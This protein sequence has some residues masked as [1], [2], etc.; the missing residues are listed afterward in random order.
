[1]SDD[2]IRTIIDKGLAR[3]TMAID[4]TA[5]EDLVLFS[6]GVPYIAHLLCIYACRAALATGRKTI[7]ASHVE[8][9]MNRSL[10]QWQQSIKA[11]YNEAIQSPRPGHIYREVLLACALAEVD[12]LRFFTTAAVRR[13]LSKIAKRD[14]DAFNYGRHLKELSEPV[15]GRVLQRVGES[16]RL[17]YRISNP[18]LRPYII[19][20]GIKDKL[21]TKDQIVEGKNGSFEH[22]GAFPVA[23]REYQPGL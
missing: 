5:R 12:E 21:I 19:M 4:D 17:R 20:R 13:P 9:G 15:R 6:Q 11:L 14:F 18:I 23:Q 3:L 2:E 10:D 16:F 1:M 22:A 7:Y 8:Q